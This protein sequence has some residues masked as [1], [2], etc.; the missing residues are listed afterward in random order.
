[1]V[2]T[3]RFYLHHKILIDRLIRTSIYWDNLYKTT[4]TK[5]GPNR[6]VVLIDRFYLHYK[7]L[8]N[9]SYSHYK[10]H[11]NKPSKQLKLQLHLYFKI[12]SF[13]TTQNQHI[14]ISEP[15]YQIYSFSGQGHYMNTQD[16][17]QFTWLIAIQ[18]PGPPV[19]TH[20]WPQAVINACQRV[21]PKVAK[22]NTA[23]TRHYQNKLHLIPS[24][25]APWGKWANAWTEGIDSP[26][27]ECIK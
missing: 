25:R 18:I 27:G 16:E 24:L 2:I 22:T 1:M 5:A 7:T 10:R 4:L 12:S 20:A 15:L 9:R 6:Q 21:S 3:E 11:H 17:Q 23:F 13:L 19:H 26:G 8:I 14:Y